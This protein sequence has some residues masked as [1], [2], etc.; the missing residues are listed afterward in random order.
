MPLL[1]AMAAAA[2]EMGAEECQGWIRHAR[3]FFPWCIA[4]EDI[5]CDVD[6]S[7]CPHRQDRRD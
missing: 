1:N 6:E 5:E 4:R 3:R 2:H 7:M